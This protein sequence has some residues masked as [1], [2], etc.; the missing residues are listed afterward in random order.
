MKEQKNKDMWGTGHITSVAILVDMAQA[1]SIV[2]ST[3]DSRQRTEAR[4]PTLPAIV[5]PVQNQKR[6]STDQRSVDAGSYIPSKESR[7]EKRANHQASTT[8]MML[9]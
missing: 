8:R 2:E 9:F 1:D 7:A 4:G 6:P 3:A 5:S